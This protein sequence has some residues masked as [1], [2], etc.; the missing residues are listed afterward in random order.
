MRARHVVLV[1]ASILCLMLPATA[2]SQERAGFWF[3]IGGGF[4]SAGVSC[5]DECGAEGREGSGVALIE[6][7][8]TLNPQTRLGLVFNFWSKDDKSDPDFAATVN[9]YNVSGAITYFP[10]PDTGFFVKGGAGV[11][12]IDVD[13]S[14]LGSGATVDLGK[15]FGFMVGAGYDIPVW[16]RVAVTPAVNFWY[17]QPGDLKIFGTTFARNWKQNVIDFTIGITIP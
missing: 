16:S 10:Q 17:G 8:W 13:F 14:G 3:G 6:G 5:D 2:F 15:G 7:G 9:L 4:G 1:V 12:I 11:A